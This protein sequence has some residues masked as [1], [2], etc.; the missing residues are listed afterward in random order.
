LGNCCT[1]SCRFCAVGTRKEILEPPRKEAILNIIEAVKRLNL[2]SVIITSVTRDDLDDGGAG[3]FADCIK[4]LKDFDAGLNVEVLVPDF[5]G[6]ESSVKKVIFAKPCVF[7]H[8][9][10]TVP[11]LYPK[12]RPGARYQRS[13]QVIRYAKMHDALLLTKSGLMVGLGEERDEVYSVMEDLKEAGCDIITIGQYLRPDSRCLEV[14]EFLHPEEFETFSEWAMELGF[15]NFSCSPF[16][17]SSQM[18][19]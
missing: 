4:L 3:H 19:P 16:T 14:E 8:N 10:E 2:R 12:V 18:Q 11:R 17:R 15:K 6:K 1:R 13:L 5:L 9:V 7:S